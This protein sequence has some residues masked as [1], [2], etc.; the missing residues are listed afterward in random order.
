MAP[1]ATQVETSHLPEASLK[2]S[3]PESITDFLNAAPDATAWGG[4]TLPGIHT[5]SDFE[6]HRQW[7]RE[8][9]AA[10][11]R[12]MGRQ[13]LAEGLA[14]HISVR[15]PEHSDRFW[16]NPYVYLLVVMDCK[17]IYE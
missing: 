11:F 10:A 2:L 13:G 14:G 1:S 15:D 9:M 5:F 4:Y 12:S 7:I 8:H 3:A 6:S 17:L 16:M